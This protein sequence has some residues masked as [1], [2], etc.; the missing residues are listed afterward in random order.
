[1]VG[2]EE[3]QVKGNISFLFFCFFSSSPPKSR[4]DGVIK[5]GVGEVLFLVI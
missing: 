5:R 3:A 2:C 1:M 4:V